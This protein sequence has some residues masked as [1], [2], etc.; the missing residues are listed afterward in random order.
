MSKPKPVESEPVESEPVES[1]PVES[2]AGDEGFSG[3]YVHLE[4][5][6]IFALKI[7]PDSE[8]K[9]H[10]TH[11]AKSLTKFGDYTAADFRRIFE[12]R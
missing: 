11:L 5:G 6:E 7:V 10:R 12:K 2:A 4:S 8:V 1:E 9:A 3:E